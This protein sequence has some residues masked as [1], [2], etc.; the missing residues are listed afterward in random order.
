MVLKPKSHEF[1]LRE[2]HCKGEI[3][4]P[5]E[6]G[7]TIRVLCDCSKNRLVHATLMPSKAKLKLSVTPIDLRKDRG[8]TVRHLQCL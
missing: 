1:E 2:R 5:H 8:K 6:F 7:Y 3:V 4:G